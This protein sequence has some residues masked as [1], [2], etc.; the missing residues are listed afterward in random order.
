M[1]AATVEVPAWLLVGLLASALL[2]MGT[3][4]SNPNGG[5]KR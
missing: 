5:N 4:L 3:L 2:Y 1:L